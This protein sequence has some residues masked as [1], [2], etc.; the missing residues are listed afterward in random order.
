MLQNV[1]I[2]VVGKVEDVSGKFGPQKKISIKQSLEGG[3]RWLSGFVD[4]KSAA[5]FE[6]GKTL[7]LEVWE[8]GKYWNFKLPSQKAKEAAKSTNE[9]MDA[10]R[11]IY[12]KL[13]DIERRLP[14]ASKTEEILS[15]FD[16][17]L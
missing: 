11:K 12:A 8:N 1:K 13:Q 6:Q 7:E 15:V 14:P 9:V 3:D 2:A 4:V 16:E 17:E 10:L 5:L